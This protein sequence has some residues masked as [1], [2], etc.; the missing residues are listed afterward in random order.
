MVQVL[1][2][3]V[4]H[5]VLQVGN[6]HHHAGLRIDGATQRNLDRVVVSMSVG[7]VAFAVDLLIN[8]VR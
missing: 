3:R 4:V 8:L 6:V 7:V 5:V 2:D 1:H